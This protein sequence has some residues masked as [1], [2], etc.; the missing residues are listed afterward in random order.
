[1]KKVT[2][3]STPALP[4]MLFAAALLF[5]VF[6][7]AQI[8][9]NWF[10]INPSQ[11]NTDRDNPNGSSGGRVQ[12]L[13]SS[14]SSQRMFAATEW[15]GLYTSFNGGVSWVRVNSFVPSAAWDVKVQPGTDRRLRVFA[16]SLYDGRSNTPIRRSLSGISISDDGGNTWRNAPLSTLPCAGANLLNEPSAFQIA[17]NPQN[18][19]QIFA[20]TN[21]GLARSLD[22]GTTW[23]YVDPSP[24]NNAEQI[25]AVA[26]HG[27]NIVD[28]I[29]GNGH[30]RSTDA[31]NTWTPV[32]NLV[33]L[34]A[35]G[36][37]LAVS[38]AE[39]NVLFAA[40]NGSIFE[41]DNGGGSWPTSIT[42]PAGNAQGRIPFVKTNQRATS[43]QFDLWYGDVSL[44][45]TTGTTPSSLPS[46]SRVPAA[47]AWTNA[48]TGAHND[49]G[50]LLFDPRASADACPLLFSNDGGVYRNLNA[51]A[52]G[53]QTPLWEQPGVTPHAT[54]LF[55]FDGTQ[56]LPGIH[57]IYYGLQDNGSWGTIGA[58]EGPSNP[59][60]GW[61]NNGCCDAFVD[62]AQS[63]LIV[64]ND[65]V[66]G[67]RA[68]R[69]FQKGANFSGGGQ[70]P[71][72]PSNGTFA[73]F[74]SGREVVRLGNKSFAVTLSDGVYMTNDITSNPIAWT[75][76]NAPGG[77]TAGNNGHLKVSR[78][79]G[80]TSIYYHTG[81]GNPNGTGQIFRRGL[82]RGDP[83]VPLP[84]PAGVGSVTVYDVDPN[85]GQ[86]LMICGI[87]NGAVAG[88]PVANNFSMWKTNNYGASWTPMPNLDGLMTGG[89]TFQNRTNNGPTNF[90]G[91]GTYWQPF[92]LQFNPN[93]GN[94]VVAGAADAGVF[95]TTNF[96][97]NWQL[98]S[99]PN[100]PSSTTPHIPRPVFAYFSPTRFT[101]TSQA[102]DV[103]IG[104]QGAG[105]TKV[106]VE[107]P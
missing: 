73:G 100:T 70:I 96:G 89:G 61:N 68:I 43:N 4:A 17:I 20:G 101:A 76:L 83:W 35:P 62:A 74:K 99:N 22:G 92:L 3:H 10:D 41:S 52:P 80:P 90:T 65:G 28:V 11:S 40:V 13:A 1:M 53:C 47:P 46:G 49:V 64:Y 55:G 102:F 88:G 60:P 39:N 6:A 33:S 82:N 69:L 87:N 67:G 54:W 24:G 38:P 59:V 86:Q 85:N 32:N 56:Q 26:A 98:I 48:Q 57:G 5:S 93:N 106:L 23:T 66:Y 72:Y 103:W 25:F 29:G 78:V 94:T 97:N 105:V 44:F 71:N 95:V 37:S 84:L 91:F 16:T 45:K 104:S 36:N 14:S 19:N 31:G 42:V 79:G 58:L 9:T 2:P 12:H 27:N 107:S 30:F 34:F 21:C 63:D 50:D 75:A 81:S 8:R 15:G 77:S 7:P 18:P 51:N